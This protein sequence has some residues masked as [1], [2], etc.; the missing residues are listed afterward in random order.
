MGR[1][2]TKKKAAARISKKAEARI[3]E[4]SFQNPDFGAKRLVSLLKQENIKASPS[5][6]YGILKNNGLQ[7]REKRLAKLEQ[8]ILPEKA[9]TT[10]KSPPKIS[11]E[12]SNQIIAA[13]LNNPEF[14]AKR[15]VSLLKDKDIEVSVSMAYAVLKRNGLQNRNAR[16]KARQ[17]I[18]AKPRIPK[19]A[20]ITISSDIEDR[21]LK[22]SLQNPDLGAKRLVPLLQES[23]IETSTSRVYT[24]LKRRGLQTRQL[25]LAKLDEL[26]STQE[27]LGPEEAATELTSEIE[28]RIVDVSLQNPDYGARRLAELMTEEGI[29]ISSAA[30]YALLKRHGMQTRTLRKSRIELD[31][32]TDDDARYGV[33]T[34]T[35]YAVQMPETTEEPEHDAEV[36]DNDEAETRPVALVTPVP[37]APVK[38]PYRARWFFYLADVLLLAL[39]GYLGYLG[40]HTVIKVKQARMAPVGVAAVKPEQARP[41]LK[42][43]PAEQPL[44]GYQKIWKR[45]LFNIPEKEVP[46][47]KKEIP[48]EKIAVAKKN[49]GLKLVGTVVAHDANFSRAIVHVSKTREQEAF[50]EGDQAGKAKIKKIL[51]NKV[52]ITTAKGDL[53]LT[54]EEKDFGKGRGSGSKQRHRPTSLKSSQSRDAGTRSGSSGARIS[55]RRT[56]SINLKRE[57]VQESLAD[58]NQLLEELTLSPFMQGDEPAGFIISK[59]PRG[60]ILTKMGLRNGYVVTQINDQTITGPEQA[61]EFFRT[62]A[63]GGE[64]SIEI[65]RSRGVKRR[66][67]QININIE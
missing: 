61:D 26:G 35:P 24:T 56:R 39:V 22:I 12:T 15:L 41:A 49:I 4:L 19:S 5:Y 30:V 28:E 65:R 57:E 25:R 37:P 53:L 13:S 33:E 38:T 59:I 55:R 47:P 10:A 1:V 42:P 67:R 51:R 32:L 31:H 64:V 36:G 60:S 11:D 44:Q 50:R 43:Q 52:I 2:I 48:I 17:D 58:T 9:S 45:N 40:Y 16:L 27:T 8:K 14:G 3:I 34:E 46:E 6:I 23:G 62:L 63:E 18:A 66:S 54:V 29:S 21:I 20:P 7:T